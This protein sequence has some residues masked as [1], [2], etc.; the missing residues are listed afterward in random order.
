PT[1]SRALRELIEKSFE[2]MDARGAE[3]AEPVDFLSAAL[4][5][6]EQSLKQDFRQ[7]G[8]TPKTIEKAAE[9]RAAT[10]DT[11][12]ARSGPR[13]T[14]PAASGRALERFG[15]DLT[16]AAAAGDLMPVIGRDDEI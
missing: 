8:I 2:K 13:P 12:G 5:F 16:A 9:G 6:S 4:E 11:V 3:M 7:A 1:A 10:R 15:R 14:T